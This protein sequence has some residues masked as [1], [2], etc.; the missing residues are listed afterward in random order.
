MRH[1]FYR[2]Q[3]LVPLWMRLKGVASAQIDL[4]Q[5]K[6]NPAEAGLV[7]R[8]RSSAKRGRGA[9]L[10]KR[11]LINP[12]LGRQAS[13]LPKQPYRRADEYCGPRKRG[14]DNPSAKCRHE[15]M[16]DMPLRSQLLAR[17]GER[18]V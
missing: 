7:G 9:Q 18:A 13:L 6:E 12:F 8:T 5:E 4:N 17:Q 16:I 3:R 15:Q 1:I 10:A 14:D 11:Q 2:L